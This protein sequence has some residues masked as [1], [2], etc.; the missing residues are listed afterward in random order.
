MERENQFPFVGHS[1]FAISE[2]LMRSG[3]AGRV[4]D[5]AFADV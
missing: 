2:T 1:V 4:L 5:G 3:L